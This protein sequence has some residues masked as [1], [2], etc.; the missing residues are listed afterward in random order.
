M[1]AAQPWA[2][3]FHND[4][5][6]MSNNVT[7]LSLPARLADA[8]PVMALAVFFTAWM[9]RSLIA[10]SANPTLLALALAL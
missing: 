1:P 2:A 5:Q 9:A 10:R 4:V 8:G 7:V 3:V 6:I